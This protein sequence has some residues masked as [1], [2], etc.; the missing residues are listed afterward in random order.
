MFKNKCIHTPTLEDYLFV[1]NWAI[2]QNIFWNNSNNRINEEYW[3]DYRSKT[4]IIIGACITYSNE[5]YAESHYG[6]IIIST[7]EF[8]SQIIDIIRDKFKQKYD[9]R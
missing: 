6:E 9:L 3:E 7:E 4:H 1:V 5:A 2:D 8:S